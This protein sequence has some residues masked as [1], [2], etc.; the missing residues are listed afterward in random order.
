MTPHPTSCVSACF[1]AI[2]VVAGSGCFGKALGQEDSPWQDDLVDRELLHRKS[3][4]FP[5]PRDVANR[6]RSVIK[7]VTTEKVEKES[8]TPTIAD[9][10]RS[11]GECSG[12]L[13]APRLVVTA[14]HCVCMT[15]AIGTLPNGPPP[16][17]STSP[18]P[19]RVLKRSDAL[20]NQ[21]LAAV[22]NSSDC[23]KTSTVETIVYDPPSPGKRPG[24]R[25]QEYLGR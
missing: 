7:V 8:Q 25:S 2:L 9:L 22:I 17:T 16:T 20:K 10:V 1:L 6:Y 24:T 21:K 18:S 14:G 11:N 4:T 12:V 13:I 15:R 23:A 5:G 3:A 19:R